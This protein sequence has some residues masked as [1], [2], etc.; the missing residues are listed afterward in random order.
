MSEGELNRTS[1]RLRHTST[2]RVLDVKPDIL[3]AVKPPISQEGKSDLNVKLA[4]AE[5]GRMAL[6]T[7]W[8]ALTWASFPA[9]ATGALFT[10]Y[11]KNAERNLAVLK[12]RNI[13]RDAPKQVGIENTAASSSGFIDVA[14][15]QLLHG[16]NAILS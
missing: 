6:V 13:G 11:L 16:P 8:A 4:S 9:G 5:L 7:E 15:D 2:P 1:K 3:E 10:R 14:D 12:A